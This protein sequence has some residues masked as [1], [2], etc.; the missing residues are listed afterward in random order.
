M[1]G[2]CIASFAILFICNSIVGATAK[3]VGKLAPWTPIDW[4]SL[5]PA[6]PSKSLQTEISILIGKILRLNIV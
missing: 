6:E 5:P 4:K 3:N 1:K 2:L